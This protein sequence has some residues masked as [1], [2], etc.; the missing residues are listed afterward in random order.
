M[1]TTFRIEVCKPIANNLDFKLFDQHHMTKRIILEYSEFL[2]QH[3]RMPYQCYLAAYNRWFMIH[4]VKSL[5]AGQIC[6]KL[7]LS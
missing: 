6:L 2:K 5:I 3:F 4:M 7:H 1:T